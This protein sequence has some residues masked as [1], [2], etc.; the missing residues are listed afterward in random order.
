MAAP[1]GGR[2]RRVQQQPPPRLKK[3]S[4]ASPLGVLPV[5]PVA[6]TIEVEEDVDGE[7]SGGAIGGSVVTTTEVEENV[8]GGASRGHY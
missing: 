5:G 3:T 1:W 8:D 2:Y 4:M 7:P 6:S